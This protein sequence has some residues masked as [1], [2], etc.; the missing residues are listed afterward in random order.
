VILLVVDCKKIP[1]FMGFVANDLRGSITIFWVPFFRV[2]PT[3]NTINKVCC[4][5]IESNNL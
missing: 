4:N 5:T 1:R 3:I 2:L